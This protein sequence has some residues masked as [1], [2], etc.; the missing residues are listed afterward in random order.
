MKSKL[1]CRVDK[2]GLVA[3]AVRSYFMSDDLTAK[4]IG[5]LTG[6]ICTGAFTEAYLLTG[7]L[8]DAVTRLIESG[9]VPYAAGIYVGRLRRTRPTFIPSH[10]FLQYSFNVLGKVV[11]AFVIGEEGLRPF[12][13]GKD[14]LKASVRECRPPLVKGDVVA[15]VGEDGFVYGVGISA[16]DSCSELRGLKRTDVVAW[17]VFDVGWYLRGGTEARERKFKV[18]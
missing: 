5:D 16:L 9:R 6:L 13:Y 10:D 12:L 14:A 17:N 1:T 15:V 18:S 7:T 4:V 11:R 8:M 3:N 2:E